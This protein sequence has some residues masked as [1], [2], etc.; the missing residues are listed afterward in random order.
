MYNRQ[1]FRMKCHIDCESC[2]FG[3]WETHCS[4]EFLSRRSALTTQTHFKSAA[5]VRA[6]GNTV[7][8]WNLLAVDVCSSQPPSLHAIN[9][10]GSMAEEQLE[11]GE[12]DTVQ[13]L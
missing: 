5:T 13:L 8:G 3:S 7:E 1:P 10:T 4:R 6:C 9:A 12:A 2:L 11:E